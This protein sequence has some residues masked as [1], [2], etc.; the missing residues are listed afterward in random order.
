MDVKSAFL[1][2]YLK[3]IYMQQSLKF[4]SHDILTFSGTNYCR[5]SWITSTKWHIKINKKENNIRI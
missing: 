1:K 4:D 2:R 5:R 3:E